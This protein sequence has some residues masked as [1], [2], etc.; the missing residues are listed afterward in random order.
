MSVRATCPGCGAELTFRTGAPLIVCDHCRSVIARRDRDLENLG[1]VV[2]LVVSESPLELWL[3]G[4]WRGARFTLVGHAQLAHPQGGVWDEWYAAFDDGRWGWLAEAQGRFH[5]TFEIEGGAERLP[6]LGSLTPGQVVTGL[7]GPGRFVVAE[8]GT[9]TR[10][11]A[12]GEIPYRL[13]PGE[14]VAFVDLS[15][16]DGAFATI[17]E[18]AAEPPELFV[19]RDVTL[20]ELG[21]ATRAP[22][23]RAAP[24]VK[25][26]RVACPE[27]DGSLEL[28]APDQTKRV[29]CPYCGTLSEVQPG[30]TL[31]KLDQLEGPPVKPALPLGAKATLHGLEW[32]L[33][34]FIHKA[35]EVDGFEYTW[36]EYLLY[37]AA[38][39]FRWLVCANGHW[40]FVVP[41]AAGDVEVDGANARVRGKTFRYFQSGKAFV[42]QVVGECYWKV[43]LGEETFTRDLVAPPHMLSSEESDGEIQWTLGTYLPR[44][45]VGKA[46]GIEDMPPDHGVAPNQPFAY[47]GVLRAWGILAAVFLVLALA[48]IATRG[49]R[50][51]VDGPVT[52]EEGVPGQP[53]VWFSEPF[54]LRSRRNLRVEVRSLLDNH[55]AF[56]QG[57]LVNDTT[58]LVQQ[59]DV[60]L[61]HYSGYEGGESW[62]EGNDGQDHVFLSA[63]PAG[64]YH[65]RLEIQTDA[66]T[67][68]FTSVTVREGVPHWLH[69]WLVLLGISIIPGF[70]LIARASFEKRR[71]A[72]SDR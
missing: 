27:C 13:R 52:F 70:V 32:R 41:L 2:D 55:W 65:M 5:L 62:R 10:R 60:A 31:A 37:R 4:T 57:D 68:P 46:F 33:V 26:V 8:V 24:E 42:K 38:E 44:R 58:G 21:W 22:A 72:E 49:T 48:V 63:L 71:W 45:E 66:L 28:G 25:A 23:E 14:T 61:E 59:F 64:T 20:A 3:T 69:F 1:K 39:G 17:S 54:E 12:A 9:A 53:I 34:G 35:T 19:G 15:G 7:P 11:G 56:V 6:P 18:E 16:E 30:G 50:T 40:S 43:R 51:V 47:N 36:D 29:G 67:V